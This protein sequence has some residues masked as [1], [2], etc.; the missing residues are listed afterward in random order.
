[1][2]TEALRLVKAYRGYKAGDVI[3]ATPNLAQVLKS[4]GVAVPDRQQTFLS[5]QGAERAVEARS[6]VEAR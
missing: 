2:E 1:V 5:E 3:R 4:E 6:N